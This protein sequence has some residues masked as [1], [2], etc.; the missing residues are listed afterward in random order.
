MAAAEQ[1]SE[2]RDA[3]HI[4]RVNRRLGRLRKGARGA[5]A[6][7]L[8]AASVGLERFLERAREHDPHG[9]AA[10]VALPAALLEADALALAFER[11][12]EQI[13]PLLRHVLVARFRRAVGVALGF[14]V[15]FG[16][17]SDGGDADCSAASPARMLRLILSEPK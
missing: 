16:S 12:V 6:P 15:F 11:R 14:R 9:P 5:A 7:M 10:L 1:G 8:S 13:D 2:D 4:A 3:E 17:S